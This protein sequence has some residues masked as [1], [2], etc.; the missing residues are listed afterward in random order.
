MYVCAYYLQL[1]AYFYFKI[2]LKLYILK[3]K[4]LESDPGSGIIMSTQSLVLQG[5]NRNTSGEYICQVREH[6]N[7]KQIALLRNFM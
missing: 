1:H 4:E 6:V 2:K 7:R 3:G 5:V